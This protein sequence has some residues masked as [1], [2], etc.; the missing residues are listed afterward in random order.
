MFSLVFRKKLIF[1]DLKPLENRMKL[2]ILL[3]SE[4]IY[5]VRVAVGAYVI[6]QKSFQITVLLKCQ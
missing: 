4:T 2:E 3:L 6:L 5:T 1:Q